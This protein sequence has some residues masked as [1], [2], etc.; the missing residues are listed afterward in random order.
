MEANQVFLI[1][2]I[3]LLTMSIVWNFTLYQANRNLEKDKHVLVQQIERCK[4]IEINK[5]KITAVHSYF[6][7]CKI[8]IDLWTGNRVDISE[9]ILNNFHFYQNNVWIDKISEDGTPIGIKVWD[10]NNGFAEI[11]S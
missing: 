5:P 9:D 2:L 8:I 1:V 4:Q 3:I 7:G 6:K 10:E 11:I